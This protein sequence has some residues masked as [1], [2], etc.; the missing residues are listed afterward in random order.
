M[1]G[2]SLWVAWRQ[3]ILATKNQRQ[4]QQLP[5][6]TEEKTSTPGDDEKVVPQA[7]SQKIEEGQGTKSEPAVAEK[8]GEIQDVIVA[9]R[10]DGG[11]K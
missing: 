7:E 3:L 1:A 11:K 6:P 5:A 4:N 10:P 8:I 9:M 2:L